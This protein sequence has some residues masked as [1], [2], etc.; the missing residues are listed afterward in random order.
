[1]SDD[2]IESSLIHKSIPK[3]FDDIKSR[4]LPQHTGND[5]SRRDSEEHPIT[6]GQLRTELGLLDAMI[7]VFRKVDDTLKTS[8]PKKLGHIGRM[9]KSTHYMLDTWID[10]QNNAGDIYNLIKDDAYKNIVSES[11]DS[12]ISDVLDDSIEKEKKEIQALKEQI[13]TERENQI[14]RKLESERIQNRPPQMRNTEIPGNMYNRSATNRVNKNTY[15]TRSNNIPSSSTSKNNYNR[16]R[17][18]TAPNE[19]LTRP[20]ASS[21]RKMF[22]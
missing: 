20:T 5:S 10:I 21:S 22:R 11:A 19:R 12:K 14:N 7:K 13:A 1:M 17:T 6:S 9:C 15:R 8:V 3:L 2:N 16:S 18:I 4:N